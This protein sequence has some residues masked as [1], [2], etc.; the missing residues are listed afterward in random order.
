MFEEIKKE[1]VDLLNRK[2]FLDMSNRAIRYYSEKKES[3]SFSIEGEWGVGK[4][5][6][7][8]KLY[9]YLFEF[10]DDTTASDKYCI[11]T[12]N[13]WE[14]DYYNEPLLS[15]LLSIKNSLQN[16]DQFIHVK[17]EHKE[18]LADM[19][20]SVAEYFI[21]PIA[22]AAATYFT[23]NPAVGL[24]LGKQTNEIYKNIKKSLDDSS[25]NRKKN[26]RKL[27]PNYDLD[28]LMDTTIKALNKITN[29]T[30]SNPHPKTIIIFIDELDRCLPEY[31]IRVLERMH[32]ITKNVS[33]IQMIYS[34][35]RTQLS[36]TISNYYGDNLNV[37]RYL[38][39]FISFSLK[40]LPG[41]I[42]NNIVKAYPE[43]FWKFDFI[44]CSQFDVSTI[45][46]IIFPQ[47]D[48]RERDS[49]IKKITFINNLIIEDNKKWDISILFF[50]IVL[51]MLKYEGIDNIPNLS[52]DINHDTR[53]ITLLEPLPQNNVAQNLDQINDFFYKLQKLLP[54]FNS[55]QLSMLDYPEMTSIEYIVYMIFSCLINQK[56]CNCTTK[57][58]LKFY[59]ETYEKILKFKAYF[60]S[61]TTDSEK[62]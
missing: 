7:I 27:N 50:E 37:D 17:D 55:F 25:E 3:V 10:Q 9:D 52:I 35:D 19:F 32:H 24:A 28:A 38:K 18:K 8:E 16:K 54:N 46:T 22:I 57:T 61:I 14:Y 51:V 1:D 31:A 56:I 62:L 26:K 34:I 48:M 13:A 59:D 47:M 42:N 30:G 33:N 60:E 12:Y 58:E 21:E 5:W 20:N 45:F 29:G 39:K 23:G 44:Y 53:K 2:P 49:I 6:I 36:Q 15:F 40:L 43:L 41:E 4:T 11:L